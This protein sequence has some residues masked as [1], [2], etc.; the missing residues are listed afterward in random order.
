MTALKE[1]KK[2]DRMLRVEPQPTQAPDLYPKEYVWNEFDQGAWTHAASMFAAAPGTSS[3]HM[4]RDCR[5]T[6]T[7]LQPV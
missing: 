4:G 6:L 3:N 2:E 5:G 1:E 7:N